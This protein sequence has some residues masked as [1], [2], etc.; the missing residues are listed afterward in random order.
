MKVKPYFIITKV[1]ESG[2]T[3]ETDLN[4]LQLTSTLG[5]NYSVN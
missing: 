1:V 5:T 4:A 3:N 2:A